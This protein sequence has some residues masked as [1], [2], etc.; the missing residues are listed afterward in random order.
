MKESYTEVEGLVSMKGVLHLYNVEI[1]VLNV[2]QKILKMF[3]SLFISVLT[4][5]GSLSVPF[6]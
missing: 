4:N 2:D 5:I 1:S 6:F 3:H